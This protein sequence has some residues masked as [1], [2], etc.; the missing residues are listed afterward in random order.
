MRTSLAISTAAVVFIAAGA[1]VAR[2]ET[3][4]AD[5]TD[6]SSHGIALPERAGAVVLTSQSG[7]P[8]GGAEAAARVAASPRRAEWRIVKV[9]PTDSVI[10]WV[11]YPQSTTRAPVVVVLHENM[12]LNVWTR[13]VAD[14]LAADGF[15]AIAPDLISIRRTGDLKAEWAPDAGRAAIQSLTEDQVRASLKAVGAF[16]LTLPNAGPKYGIVGF[17]WGGQRSFGHAVYSPTLGASVVYYGNT[18]SQAQMDSIRAPVLGLYGGNDA[19][20][21]AAVPATDSAMKA[22]GKVFESHVFPGAAHGFL[23]AQDPGAGGANFD[24]AKAA[25]PLTVAW[26]RKHLSN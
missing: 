1:I 2:S 22:R 3:G 21:T 23:R 14:Q 24:A 18:P 26:F 6:H 4:N 16:G 10:S 13:A 11:V 25:W 12:G 7:L 5:E 17:C 8:A 20:I 15:I 9:G 19:R